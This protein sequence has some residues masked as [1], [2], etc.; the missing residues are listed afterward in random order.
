MHKFCEILIFL[1]DNKFLEYK[2]AWHKTIHLISIIGDYCPYSIHNKPEVQNMQCTGR[3]APFGNF[4]GLNKVFV[5]SSQLKN[6][7]LVTNCRSMRR[8]VKYKACLHQLSEF[9]K[10]I[11]HGQC[12]DH[13]QPIPYAHTQTRS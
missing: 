4:T 2:K 6:M 1:D 7:L 10:I 9:M 13:K 11:V 5:V 3:C 12:A 8:T